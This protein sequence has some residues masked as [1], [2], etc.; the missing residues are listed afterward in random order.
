M[1][2]QRS[3]AILRKSP[4]A[5][6]CPHHPLPKPLLRAGGGSPF[7]LASRLSATVN[8]KLRG[9]TTYATGELEE[10]RRPGKASSRQGDANEEGEALGGERMLTFVEKV[11]RRR[12]P[13]TPRVED[14]GSTSSAE[15]RTGSEERRTTS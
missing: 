13:A 6:D 7:V 3:I 12:R 9:V 10:A 11:L 14:Q 15:V 5:G 2:L 4:E 1:L 8:K